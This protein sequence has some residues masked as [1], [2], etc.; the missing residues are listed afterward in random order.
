MGQGSVHDIVVIGG[1]PGGYATAFR[2][3]ARGMDVALVEADHVGGTCL[4]RGCIPSK[5]N[6]HVAGV[7]EE[8][9]RS[10]D[11]GV[12]VAFGGIDGKTLDAFRS[13]VINQLRVGLARLVRER[14][15][16]HEGVGRIVKARDQPKVVE[17]ITADG[18]GRVEARH[19][20]LAT[21]SVP[22]SLPSIDVDGEVVQT[23]DQALWFTEPP[24]KAVI[25]GAGA[26]G[27]EFASMWS[28]MGSEV[29][30]VEAL[31]RIL[32]LEDP[33]CSTAV[34]R[35]Y[36]RRGINVVTSARVEAVERDGAV[37]HVRVAVGGEQ[38]EF[39]GDLVLIAVGRT[40]STA[41]IGIEELGIL[42]ERGF[43]H[44]D[45]WGATAVDGVW[46]VGDV[47]DTLALAHAAFAEGF[48][49]ADRIAGAPRTQPVDHTH[50]PRVTYCHP[51][52]ASVGLTEPEARQ[53]FGDDAVRATR[54]S[55]RANAK[56]I[57]AASDGFV[58]VVTRATWGNT[59][60]SQSESGEV[61]G[62][63]VVG[64][65]ATELIGEATLATAWEALPSELAAIT[66]AHP[67]LY[68]ALG[69]AFQAAAGMAFHA[70]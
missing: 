12:R 48:V 45:E 5:T 42:D 10:E 47:R 61:L 17:V 49:V 60:S 7:I 13:G 56:G 59:P 41:G 33:D 14:T 66:H 1:G 22:R 37:G 34:E 38:Q 53:R 27:M 70:H 20:V 16:F 68:E 57:I 24:K 30:I 69:E 39:E 50:T 23:S 11:F 67:T 44:T 55:L 3:A 58:K 6:L 35:A 64:P 15:T 62:V 28:P 31:D 65:H 32:P 19:V 4:N 63:H 29:T 40:P 36:R 8:I 54:Y 43:I 51:E 46:A 26:I 2:A 21:G 18:T 52:V 25:I 9:R